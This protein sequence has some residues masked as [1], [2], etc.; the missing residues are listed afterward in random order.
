MHEDSH[1][2][3]RGRIRHYIDSNTTYL[4]S[5]DT[6][7]SGYIPERIAG[8]HFSQ[9]HVTNSHDSHVQSDDNSAHIS[10]TPVH[11]PTSLAEDDSYSIPSSPSLGYYSQNSRPASQTGF[12]IDQGTSSLNLVMPSSAMFSKGREPTAEGDSLGFVKMMVTGKNRTWNSRVIQEM[13]K[14]DGIIAN[15]YE[16]EFL[17]EHQSH[18]SIETEQTSDTSNTNNSHMAQGS[19]SGSVSSQQ[20]VQ[21]RYQGVTRVIVE[22]YA[23]SMVLPGWAR[24]GLDDQ[25][26]QQEILIKNVCFVDTPGYSSFNNPIHGMD[27]A[28]SY[29]GL[30]FQTTNEFF[31]KSASSNDSLGRFLANNTTGAHSHVDV[32]LYIIED[33]LTDTDI[34]FMRRLQPWVN[35]LPVLIIKRSSGNQ[36]G[37]NSTQYDTN[38]DRVRKGLIKQLKDNEIDIYGVEEHNSRSVSTLSPY[39]V[40]TS[41]DEGISPPLMPL[42]GGLQPPEYASPPF[43]I[44]I[45]EDSDENTQ[46]GRVDKDVQRLDVTRDR[47]DID[48][49]STLPLPFIPLL[50][51]G[52][53]EWSEMDSAR[54]WI[55]TRNLAALRHQTTLK[56]LRWRRHQI[57]SAPSIMTS[58]H[59]SDSFPQLNL[60]N[61]RQQNYPFISEYLEMTSTSSP[62]SVTSPLPLPSELL[63][64]LLYA[65]QRRIS[66]KAA[67]ILE[68][69]GQAFERIMMEKKTAWQFALDEIEREQRVDFL[70]QEL[71]RW[72]VEGT[73][74]KYS[75]HKGDRSHGSN[76]TN[77]TSRTPSH[78]VHMET[79][80]P[81]VNRPV[82]HGRSSSKQSSGRHKSSRKKNATSSFTVQDHLSDEQGNIEDNADPLGLEMWVGQFLGALGRGAINTL[83]GT[84][85]N[86]GGVITI[87]DWFKC[88]TAYRRP[89]TFTTGYII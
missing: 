65:D 82:V 56:F 19:G 1:R 20:S 61:N 16:D 4:N 3:E 39:S 57:S 42:G 66:L 45:P 86:L 40:N 89:M 64:D 27:L 11:Y 34:V 32:C 54:K 85:G 47:N 13:F 38:A 2:A 74:Q 44:F 67:M 59:G 25:E 70:V 30:Q 53:F 14:W 62:P 78:G 52:R 71:K 18:E 80:I 81:P 55:Y 43:I 76:S 46:L 37:L 68:T 10:R 35:L 58:S 23:S 60:S 84:S 9:Q 5:A 77:Y 72:A 63:S 51:H 17:Q 48:Q 79:S 41:Q 24:A 28:V 29:L 75:R 8:S 87:S 21:D 49:Y 7:G 33:R 15:D 88:I 50:A 31:S 12:W 83:L 69:H 22:R 36:S 6:E 26:I 73:L